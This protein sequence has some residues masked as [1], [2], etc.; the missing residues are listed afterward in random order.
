MPANIYDKKSYGHR[1]SVVVGPAATVVISA[2]YRYHVS[3]RHDGSAGKDNDDEN[4][5]A[6]D[7]ADESDANRVREFA[8]YTAAPY[9]TATGRNRLNWLFPCLLS[10]RSGYQ[11]VRVARLRFW[12]TV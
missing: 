2:V 5:D 8:C 10:F 1:S 4:D 9:K 11:N 3:E 7:D 6:A 12:M